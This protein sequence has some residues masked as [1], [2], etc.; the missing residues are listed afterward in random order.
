[1][2]SALDGTHIIATPPSHDLI[3]YIGRSSK[4][5]QN[6][7]AMVDFDLRFTYASIDQPWSMQDTSV[8]FHA[9]DR[10][11]DK[12]THPSS[13]IMLMPDTLIAVDTWRHIRVKD[14][15]YQIGGGVMH[16]V[17][18]KRCLTIR[19]PVLAMRWNTHLV[20]GK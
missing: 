17:V 13:I 1:C 14:I 19:I 12:F 10:D 2:I 15:M 11:Q 4:P 5:S 3:R 18:S 16:R 8:L 9:L 6:V 20:C 7:L